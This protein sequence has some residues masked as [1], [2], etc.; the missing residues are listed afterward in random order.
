M[1]KQTLNITL[2][3][4]KYV[5]AFLSSILFL[6]TLPPFRQS[7]IAAIAIVPLLLLVDVK[8]SFWKNF[9]IG[10]FIYLPYVGIFLSWLIKY[11]FWNYLDALFSCS[12]FLGLFLSF[13]CLILK[14]F[15]QNLVLHFLIPPIVWIIISFI[16]DLTPLSGV[17]NQLLFYQTMEWMQIC[18]YFGI[19]GVVFLFLLFNSSIAI[20]FKFHSW[21]KWI[22]S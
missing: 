19:Y 2:V 13:S 15:P 11:D 16:Y 20:I 6:L 1:V 7:W 18:R 14:R 10:T 8:N 22:G 21:K 4:S 12:L 5:L 17:V 3:S 9:L